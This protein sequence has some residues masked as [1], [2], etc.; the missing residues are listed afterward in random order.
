MRSINGEKDRYV[1]RL[2]REN[3]VHGFDKRKHAVK[4][5]DVYVIE[6]SWGAIFNGG[7]STWR[8]WLKTK[9]RGSRLVQ[10]KEIMFNN[11]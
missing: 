8:L 4:I 1:C 2:S 11:H 3:G 6:K 10:N 9:K 7:A 5:A